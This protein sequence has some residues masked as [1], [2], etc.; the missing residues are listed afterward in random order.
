MKPHEWSDRYRTQNTKW[1]LGSSP[2]LLKA[3]IAGLSEGQKVLI[4]G[5]GYGYEIKDFY[6]E[7]HAV[8]AVDFSEGAIESAREVIGY[9]ADAIICND[10]FETPLVEGSFDLCYERTFFCAISMERWKDYGP[11][12]ANLL[13]ESGILVG[14]YQYGKPDPDGPPFPMTFEDR[15]RYIEPYFSLLHDEPAHSG[16]SVF[17][18]HDERW[19]IWQKQ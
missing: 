10:F 16:L 19:Q 3:Y 14:I 12:I 2:P 6:E 11:R 4:P 13:S 8:T 18:D 15:E 7:G 5:C 1:D 17:D 9:L